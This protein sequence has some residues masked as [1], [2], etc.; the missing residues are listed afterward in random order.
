[1]I[2]DILGL[3][4]GPGSATVWRARAAVPGPLRDSEIRVLRYLPTHLTLPEIARRTARLA[5]H[6]QDPHPQP[7]HQARRARPG[8]GRRPRP[9]SGAAR[10]R[11]VPSLAQPAGPHRRLAVPAPGL[12]GNRP[13]RAIGWSPC[14]GPNCSENPAGPRRGIIS[15]SSPGHSP[16]RARPLHGRAARDRQA[17]RS[18]AAGTRSASADGWAR[19]SGPRSRAA[20]PGPGRRH[21][22]RHVLA[23]QAALYG[24]LTECEA[25]GLELLEVRSLD[26]HNDQH[27]AAQSPQ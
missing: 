11:R 19:R 20:D 15:S 1:M 7:V 10:A 12:P 27:E 13:D 22:S 25:L 2:A 23:D 18:S 4:A 26:Q 8:R 5:Q 17:S 14:P 21:G 16:Q 24:V 3:L 6:R 9:R